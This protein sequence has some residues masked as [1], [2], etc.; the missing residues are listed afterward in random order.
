MHRIWTTMNRFLPSNNRRV[1]LTSSI[2]A[3][4]CRCQTIS[5]CDSKRLVNW[6]MVLLADRS[7]SITVCATSTKMRRNVSCA[8]STI[9]TMK[10]KQRQWKWIANN[11]NKDYPATVAEQ[12]TSG[13][14]GSLAL[15]VQ[16]VVRDCVPIAVFGWHCVRMRHWKNKTTN[17]T[18]K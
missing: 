2:L 5:Y 15:I 9:P 6:K 18:K 8:S 11:R 12:T 1:R 16:P 14:S 17:L 13:Q 10:T 3:Q 7:Q 4:R